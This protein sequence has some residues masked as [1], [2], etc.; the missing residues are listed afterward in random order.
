MQVDVSHASH[1]PSKSEQQSST[2]PHPGW[3]AQEL[4]L[5]QVVRAEPYVK[6]QPV[7]GYKRDTNPREQPPAHEHTRE[8]ITQ[9][10]RTPHFVS[11]T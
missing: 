11:H 6:Q 9:G 7:E 10:G 5:G 1:P 2:H 8:A 3:L 4:V